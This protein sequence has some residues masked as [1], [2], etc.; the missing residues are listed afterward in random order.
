M[1]LLAISVDLLLFEIDDEVIVGLFDICSKLG[2]ESLL[3][4]SEIPNRRV[5]CRR[6][7]FFFPSDV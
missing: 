3:I 1:S 4:G 6:V 5:H 2:T 7:E